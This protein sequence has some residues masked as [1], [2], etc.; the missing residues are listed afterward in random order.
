V[1]DIRRKLEV[2]G[3]HSSLHDDEAFARAHGYETIVS[4][5]SMVRVWAMPAY[6]LPGQQA[7]GAEPF[8]TPVPGQLVPGPG[9]ALIAVG[10]RMEYRAPLYPGDRVSSVA[11]LTRV[12]PKETRVGP[13]AF[14]DVETTYANQRGETVTLETVTFLRYTLRPGVSH[15]EATPPAVVPAGEEL[16]PFRVSLTL[17]RLVMEAGA[18]RDF[19]PIHHSPEAALASGAAGVFANTTFVETVIEALLRTPGPARRRGSP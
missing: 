7:P 19:S 3:F 11:V 4:P 17:Q 18:S 15:D 12:T 9:E 2:I 1:S 8:H 5:V 16:P 13:G 10:V 14:F 6:W